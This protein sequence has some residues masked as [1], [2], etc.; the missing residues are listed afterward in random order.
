MNKKKLRFMTDI[1]GFT[2]F[3]IAV[4]CMM[5]AL[6]SHFVDCDNL[7][8]DTLFAILVMIIQYSLKCIDNGFA[9][10]FT[11]VVV[12]G[13]WIAFLTTGI[14]KGPEM[15]I[16][17][18]M[19]AAMFFVH[20]H[21]KGDEPTVKPTAASVAGIVVIILAYAICNTDYPGYCYNVFTYLL[22][23]CIALLFIN[24]YM[25]NLYTFYEGN[26]TAGILN[27]STQI[28]ISKKLVTVF[29]TVCTLIMCA[30][31]FIPSTNIGT[32]IKR[33]LFLLAR[34][35]LSHVEGGKDPEII[36]REPLPQITT[37]P[38]Q[39]QHATTPVKA[40]SLFDFD[41]FLKYLIIP[42]IILLIIGIMAAFIIWIKSLDKNDAEEEKSFISPFSADN[43]KKVAKLPEEKKLSDGL[44]SS[45]FV[46][47]PRKRIRLA[48]KKAIYVNCDI[49]KKISPS[50]TPS[51]LCE[52]TTVKDN[53]N[54][55]KTLYEQA[56]YSDVTCT[57]EQAK[58]AENILK[59]L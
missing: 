18:V 37:E 40:P 54:E 42:L 17:S 9:F 57:K 3:L 16:F 25:V 8:T 13:A 52:I 51:Q 44:F 21:S 19:I 34:W 50:Y 20:L 46:R 15:I 55:L 14:L 43:P 56:R 23:T 4:Y 27:Y 28:N 5:I 49:N 32:V 6:T 41:R 48:F 1:S 47:D 39:A 30:C 59:N 11:H 24:R 7:L 10:F 22:I 26:S 12:I 45:I 35:L 2:I 38:S 29:L 53:L 36:E 31:S 33:I 58:Q